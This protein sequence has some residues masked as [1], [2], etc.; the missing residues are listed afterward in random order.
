MRTCR[1]SCKGLFYRLQLHRPC[2]CR[3]ALYS[4][5]QF[6]EKTFVA[7]AYSIHSQ[8]LFC[9]GEIKKD[10]RPTISSLQT[11]ERNGTLIR[12]T[13]N[14]H[15]LS[16]GRCTNLN[17]SKY[18][19]TYNQATVYTYDHRVINCIAYTQASGVLSDIATFCQPAVT[20]IHAMVLIVQACSHSKLVY[21]IYIM[22]SNH[23]LS[24]RT[25]C[26]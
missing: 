18:A 5:V 13:C 21:V 6:P 10:Q 23:M 1:P 19:V 3:V 2:T 14:A 25:H 20:I 17:D 8:S 16:E 11:Y 4:T 26:C 22:F 15:N 7:L 24:F 12:I 9:L